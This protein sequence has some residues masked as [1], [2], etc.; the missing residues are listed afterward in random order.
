MLPAVR[1]VSLERKL[2]LFISLLLLVVIAVLALSSAREVQQLAIL[3]AR[4]RLESISSQLATSSSDGYRRRIAALVA[5]GRSDTLVHLAQSPTA[6]TRAAAQK[7]LAALTTDTAQDLGAQVRD[8]DGTVIFELPRVS[9]E[10]LRFAHA[11]KDSAGFGPLVRNGEGFAYSS[12]APIVANGT[13]VGRLTIWRKLQTSARSVRAVADLIGQNGAVYIG[14]PSG[15]IWIDLA[16]HP[17]TR[18]PVTDPRGGFIAFDRPSGPQ[19]AMVRPMVGTPWQIEVDFPRTA[20]LQGQQ[21]FLRRVGLTAL[22]LLVL[23]ALTGLAISRSI[24]RPLREITEAAQQ[25]GAG[26]YTVRIS[27]YRDD[28]VGRLARLAVHR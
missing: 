28:E 15:D 9:L 11:V 4:S 21:T 25:M 5:A 14:N 1:G 22:I 17:A 2:P 26:D 8:R 6:A 27:G 3:S 24:T 10:G 20:I 13:I 18:A 19:L 23:G 7:M 12:G 16:G